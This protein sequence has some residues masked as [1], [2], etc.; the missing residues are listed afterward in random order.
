[1]LM[2]DTVLLFCTFGVKEGNRKEMNTRNKGTLLHR[3][4]F[5]IILFFER[6]E[7]NNY[8]TVHR[9]EIKAL[10]YIF[11]LSDSRLEYLQRFV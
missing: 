11:I 9:D 8:S 7:K 5:K 2:I 6:R 1:M 10:N 3:G 4:K